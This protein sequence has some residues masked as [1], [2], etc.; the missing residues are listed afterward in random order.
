MHTSLIFGLKF[1]FTRIMRLMSNFTSQQ[2]W[3]H[4]HHFHI[5]S[6]R[7][8]FRRL[9]NRFW[10]RTAGMIKGKKAESKPL[11]QSWIFIF[12]ENGDY[13]ILHSSTDFVYLPK[14]LKMRRFSLHCEFTT[15]FITISFYANFFIHWT[16]YSFHE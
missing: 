6:H 8:W 1:L 10:Y 3:K 11:Q 2:L 5:S 16:I 13:C 12:S 15:I 9:G 4:W 7:R 14:W